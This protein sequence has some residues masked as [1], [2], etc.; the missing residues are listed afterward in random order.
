[1]EIQKLW[2][3]SKQLLVKA[4]YLLQKVLLPGEAGC[5]AQTRHL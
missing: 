3:W 1:L 4:W 2:A 5:A